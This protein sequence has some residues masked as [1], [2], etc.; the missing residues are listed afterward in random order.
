MNCGLPKSFFKR[1]YLTIYGTNS[2]V[3]VHCAKFVKKD[4]K[5]TLYNSTLY[6]FHFL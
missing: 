3:K 6:D 2:I 1:I 4:E 5:H